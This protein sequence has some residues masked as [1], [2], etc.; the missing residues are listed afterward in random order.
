MVDS[1]A[2]QD[3]ADVQFLEWA[4]MDGG[5]V[6]FEAGHALRFDLPR[7]AVAQQLDHTLQRGALARQA[8][9]A[10]PPNGEGTP[11]CNRRSGGLPAF[12]CLSRPLAACFRP[13]LLDR[14]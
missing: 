3:D 1:C 10:R 14:I 12:T 7:P 2:D 8:G 6:V 11:S 13:I 9:C 5:L 4:A